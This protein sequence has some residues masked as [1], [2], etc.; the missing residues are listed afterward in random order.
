M[1]GLNLEPPKENVIF[2]SL[3]DNGVEKSSLIGH[4]MNRLFDLKLSLVKSCGLLILTVQVTQRVVRN[5]VTR[6]AAGEQRKSNFQPHL[7]IMRRRNAG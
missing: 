2:S 5:H 7:M 6:S 3:K 4:E 1:A